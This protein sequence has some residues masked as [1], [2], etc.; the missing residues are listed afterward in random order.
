MLFEVTVCGLPAGVRGRLSPL[1][2]C[3]AA[4]AAMVCVAAWSAMPSAASDPSAAAGVAGVAGVA[5][6][7]SWEN[8]RMIDS[9]SQS[10]VGWRAPTSASR[11][12]AVGRSAGVLGQ[13]ALDQRPHFGRHPV[14]A[15]GVMDHAVQQRRRGPGAERALARGG[16]GEH[17]PEAEDVAR[18]PDLVTGGLL[19]GHEPGR[20][21]PG[22]ACVSCVDSTAWEM[23][24]SMTRGPSSASSTFDGLRSR[25]TTPARVDRAQ[26]LRQAR[27]QRQQRPRRQRP[28]RIHPLRQ[29][30][31]GN[32]GGRQPRHWAVDVRVHHHG[33]EHAAD[34]P[35]RGDLLPEPH[36]ELRIC[37]QLIADDLD[38]DRP[39]ARGDAKEHSP[40]ATAAELAYEP[41]R[42][43]RLRILGLQSSDHAAPNVTQNDRNNDNDT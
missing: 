41:V 21:Q 13:A 4:P 3:A 34:P 43:D 1:G 9:G 18:R 20:T 37:G 35:R 12:S 28:A 25:C 16:E 14:Q 36:P 27:G 26:A 10:G 39:A 23:P 7:G 24:K 8:A 32:I 5:G 15:G 42:T 11:P 40:H 30:R 33:R 38:R 22:P 19:R 31:P 6:A 29:R 17:R 2:T